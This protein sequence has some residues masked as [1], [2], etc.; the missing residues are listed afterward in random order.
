MD[1]MED[2]NHENN[3]LA[4]NFYE[5][6]D[7]LFWINDEN[8]YRRVLGNKFLEISLWYHHNRGYSSVIMTP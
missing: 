2:F 6:Y 4:D 7:E 5:D 1:F 8:V 3:L